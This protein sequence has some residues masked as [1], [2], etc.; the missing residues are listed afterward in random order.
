M[1]ALIIV[2]VL[3]LLW[4]IQYYV[5]ELQIAL[6]VIKYQSELIDLMIIILKMKGDRTECNDG[7]K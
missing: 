6:D 1:E 3:G 4:I 2:G 7:Q 5:K